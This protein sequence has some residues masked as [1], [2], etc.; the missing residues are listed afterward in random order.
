MTARSLLVTRTVLALSDLQLWQPGTFTVLGD[1]FGPGAQVRRRETVTSPYVKGR[2]LLSAVDDVQLASLSIEVGS[3]SGSGL[4]TN[5]AVLL[6]AFS[7][8]TFTMSAIWDDVAVSWTC[9]A[10]DYAV[11]PAGVLQDHD[12]KFFTQVVALTVPRS[13][14]AVSGAF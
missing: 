5:I 14:V 9:E 3:T 7:Q 10:A 4:S 6:A 8:S 13:P 2:T 11:G 1:A 12:L